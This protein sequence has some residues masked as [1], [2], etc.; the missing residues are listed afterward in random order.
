MQEK[1]FLAS[2]V[3]ECPLGL[4]KRMATIKT[5]GFVNKPDS[6]AEVVILDR[7]G[8]EEKLPISTL[9]ELTGFKISMDCLTMKEI[10]GM[11]VSAYYKDGIFIGV[12]YRC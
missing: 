3:K 4:E 12:S 8:K 7:D 10:E 2:G 11:L 1:I 6:I 5:A 9:K